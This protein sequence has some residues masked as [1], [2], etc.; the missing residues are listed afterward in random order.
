MFEVGFAVEV[1]PE[2][3]ADG[4]EPPQRIPRDLPRI[5]AILRLTAPGADAW[6]IAIGQPNWW[7]TPIPTAIAFISDLTG[8]LVDVAERRILY[9]E[10]PVTRIWQAQESDLL[11]MVSFG[12]VTAIGPTG[13]VWR[14]KRLAY[15]DLKVTA[16]D[17]T[18]IVCRGM[19]DVNDLFTGIPSE[20]A[21]D[22]LTG[23]Q[24]SGPVFRG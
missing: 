8:F 19:V 24:L 23:E 17:L 10:E 11:L 9:E 15:D 13:V 20:I 14:S 7:R 21:I 16:S 2:F 1:D 18:R 6:D 4:G 12:D 22:P 5:G 3:P